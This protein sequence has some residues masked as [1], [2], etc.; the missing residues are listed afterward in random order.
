MGH[1]AQDW[2]HRHKYDECDRCDESSKKCARQDNIDK[3]EAKEA[4]NERNKPDLGLHKQDM[5]IAERMNV[6]AQL[7]RSRPQN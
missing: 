3:A 7:Q 1:A 6:P 2:M 5:T 4:Q